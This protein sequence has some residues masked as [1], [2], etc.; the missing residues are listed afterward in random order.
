MSNSLRAIPKKVGPNRSVISA[1]LLLYESKAKPLFYVV[2]DGRYQNV[3]F[4]KR[5]FKRRYRFK[6]DKFHNMTIF[7][8]LEK[9]LGNHAN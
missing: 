4:L 1:D 2:M 8:L 6:Q 9:I 7:E 5:H 3:Q